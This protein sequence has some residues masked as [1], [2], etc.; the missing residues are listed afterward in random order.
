MNKGTAVVVRIDDV[1]DIP[2]KDNLQLVRIGDYYSV[3]DK[4]AFHPGQLAVFIFDRCI[5]P[6]ALIE[7]LGATGKLSGKQC[8]TV[9]SRDVAGCFSHGILFPVDAIT[10]SV[11]GDHSFPYVAIPSEED[12]DEIGILHPV[13]EGMDVTK[14]LGIIPT[15]AK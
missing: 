6:K 3:A 10:T 7:A 11:G 1:N 5:L 8:D 12:E 4:N 9:R 13:Y 14:A 15:F 2:G